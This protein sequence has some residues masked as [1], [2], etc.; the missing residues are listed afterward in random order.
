MTA[1]RWAYT[2]EQGSTFVDE[3][4]VP[5]SAIPNIVNLVGYSAQ[6]EL[7]TKRKGDTG[8]IQVATFVA[9]VVEPM[10]NKIKIALDDSVTT[11]I[12]DK[13]GHFNVEVTDG[14]NTYR[15]REGPWNLS[16]DTF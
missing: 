14:S 12:T 10:G 5:A 16:Q 3:F 13:K 6:G 7:T 11:L 2:I 9:T 4:V 15:V 1:E 8:N